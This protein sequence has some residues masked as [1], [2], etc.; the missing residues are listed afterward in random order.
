MAYLRKRGSEDADDDSAELI[1]GELIGNVV[2]HAPGPIWVDVRW[3]TGRFPVLRIADRGAGF[4]L[5]PMLP[6]SL[7]AESGRGLFLV[8]VYSDDLRIEPNPG[9]GTQVSVTLK[10]PRRHDPMKRPLSTATPEQSP[11]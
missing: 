7:L 4:T 10:I 5:R 3:E 8:D 11:R 2:R 6:Q 9:G 1:F